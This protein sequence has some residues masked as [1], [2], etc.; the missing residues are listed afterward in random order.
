M[1]S[2]PLDCQVEE[3]MQQKSE[4]FLHRTPDDLEDVWN[5]NLADKIWDIKQ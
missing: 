1:K 4:I 3:A 2:P 5:T